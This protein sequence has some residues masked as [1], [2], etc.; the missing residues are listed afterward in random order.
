MMFQYFQSTQHDF[1]QQIMMSNQKNFQ[2][3]MIMQQQHFQQTML[4]AHQNNQKYQISQTFHVQS[5]YSTRIYSNENEQSRYQ[6]SSTMYWR[7]DANFS[8][9]ETNVALFLF[10]PKTRSDEKFKSE[11]NLTDI[12]RKH[13]SI[14]NYTFFIKFDFESKSCSSISMS[15]IVNTEQENKNFRRVESQF[16]YSLIRIQTFSSTLKNTIDSKFYSLSSEFFLDIDENVMKK[17]NSMIRIVKTQQE[18]KNFSRFESKSMSSLVKM[19]T[20]SSI[21]KHKIDFKS[22]SQFSKFFLDI[23]EDT[24][25]ENSSMINIVNTQQENKNH[26]RFESKSMNSLVRMQ[27]LSSTFK[28][29]ID[30][31]SYS[32]YF[33]SFLDIDENEMKNNSNSEYL[34]LIEKFKKFL[35][36]MSSHCNVLFDVFIDIFRWAFHDRF[37]KIRFRIHTQFDFFVLLIHSITIW[38][39]FSTCISTISFSF[40]TSLHQIHCLSE[41]W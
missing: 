31:K 22:H 25:K 2:R 6:I 8:L 4:T 23:D 24:M 35:F 1:F 9:Q 11:I 26:S 12:Q 17:N 18:D 20:L 14:L 28:H 38:K 33:E 27:T 7:R 19:Q 30:F 3:S 15:E 10:K 39:D 36:Q 32:Q 16:T 21:F 34:N 29:K 37:K 41:F 13:Q 40:C 5:D